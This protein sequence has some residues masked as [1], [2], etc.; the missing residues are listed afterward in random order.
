M[1]S[2]KLTPETEQWVVQQAMSGQDPQS[3]VARLLNEGWAE[4]EAADA[5]QLAVETF[6]TQASRSAGLPL[7]SRVPATFELN[8]ASVIDAGDRHVQVLASMLLPRVVVLGG[9]LADDECDELVEAARPKL[10]RSTTVN[11]QTGGDLVHAARTSRGTYFERG[12]TDLC[13]RI[14][15][16]IARVLDWPLENGEGLQILNYGAGAEYKPH[17]D[18]FDPEL[19]GSEVLL[20][21]GGQR[22]ATVV[23]YL[24]T[25]ARGGATTFPESHF[26]VGA[27]K[28][29]AVFFSYDRPHPMTKSLHGGAPVIAGEKWVATKWLRES[30]HQ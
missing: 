26:E 16:R 10:R 29:N 4:Q 9:L 15:Q 7:P 11:M 13:M 12:A 3:V 24:N 22:V 6:I 8:G 30:K 5:V 17:H 27:V 18:Y 19:P 23:M 20:Q 21:R 2:R 25:P 1:Q 28:G 14:E